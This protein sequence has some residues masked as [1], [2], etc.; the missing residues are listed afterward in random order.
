MKAVMGRL[1]SPGGRTLALGSVLVALLALPAAAEATTIT[2]TTSSDV[3]AGQC[4]L[5]SAI[6][7]ANTDTFTE[8]CPAGSPLPAVDTIQFAA[9]IGNTILAATPLPPVLGKLSIAGPGPGR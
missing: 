4:T 7:A 3:A 5:R 2:V 9:G 8:A 1:L 6:V